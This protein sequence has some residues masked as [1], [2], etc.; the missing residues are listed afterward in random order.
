MFMLE[1]WNTS[2]LTWQLLSG[3]LAG[4]TCRHADD[5]STSFPWSHPMKSNLAALLTL[6]ALVL[7]GGLELNAGVGTTYRF[8]A[9]DRPSAKL[10]GAQRDAAPNNISRPQEKTRATGNRTIS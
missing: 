10:S 9:P 6:G 8:P 7:T 4:S 5:P 1:F 3:K 2:D